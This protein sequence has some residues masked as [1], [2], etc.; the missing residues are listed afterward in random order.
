MIISAVIIIIV[1]IAICGYCRPQISG[2]WGEK[3]V[4]VRLGFLPKKQYI[5]LNNILLKLNDKT[6][7][8]DHLIVSLY[9]IFVIET[10]NHKGWIYGH[11]NQEYWTQNIWGNKYT[12]YNPIFQNNSHIKQL[13]KL[14]PDYHNIPYFSIVVFNKAS[15]LRIYGCSEN[16]LYG[17]ELYYYI[18]SYTQEVLDIAICEEIAQTI[19]NAKETKRT[20]RTEHKRNVQK[21]IT[22]QRYKIANNICPLCGKQLERRQGPYGYFWGCTNYPQCRYTKKGDSF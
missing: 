8:I 17:S 15:M 20:I 4:S 2:F 9:G 14:L 1:I 22:E 6:T 11:T 16:V 13:K 19:I 18:K 10:K 12:L 21:A 7:Q 5:V 3:A